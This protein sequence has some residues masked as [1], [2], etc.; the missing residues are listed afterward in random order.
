[1]SVSCRLHRLVY[2]FRPQP[3]QFE[4]TLYKAARTITVSLAIFEVGEGGFPS[5]A[6]QRSRI[7]L[8]QPGH[9]RKGLAAQ[10]CNA[11]L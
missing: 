4:C 6:A 3:R 1:M 9:I 11:I 7:R 8:G 2:L 5:K 10:W